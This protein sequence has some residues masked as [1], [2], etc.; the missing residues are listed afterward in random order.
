MDVLE[1]ATGTVTLQGRTA[2]PE[3]LEVRQPRKFSTRRPPCACCLKRGP[4]SSKRNVTA[5]TTPSSGP[6][7]DDTNSIVLSLVR[8]AWVSDAL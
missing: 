6:T 2:A 1:Y 7:Y 5:S 4:V 8:L 3:L